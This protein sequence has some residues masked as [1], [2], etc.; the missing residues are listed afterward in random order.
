MAS[1]LP[2]LLPVIPVLLKILKY[3]SQVTMPPKTDWTQALLSANAEVRAE[4]DQA[5]RSKT[6]VNYRPQMEALTAAPWRTGAITSVVSLS[7]WISNP[8]P[9]TLPEP[10]RSV[11]SEASH[12]EAS[13]LDMDLDKGPPGPSLSYELVKHLPGFSLPS[14]LE[15]TVCPSFMISRCLFFTDFLHSPGPF[16]YCSRQLRPAV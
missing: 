10:A 5:L 7:E 15:W 14:P 6:A 11:V 12:P 1:S 13:V 2:A 8:A 9:P 4:L 16:F 3:I